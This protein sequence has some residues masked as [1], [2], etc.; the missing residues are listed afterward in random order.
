MIYEKILLVLLFTVL[1]PN[2]YAAIESSTEHG[3]LQIDSEVYEI[4]PD[5]PTILKISG[6]INDIKGDTRV[7]IVVA[8]PD[9]LTTGLHT[10]PTKDGYFETFWILDEQSQLGQYK[11]IASYASIPLGE[12]TFE[13]KEKEYSEE[14][15]LTAR[16]LLDQIQEEKEATPEE[17]IQTENESPEPT[18]IEKEEDNEPS[19]YE[20]GLEKLNERKY[21]D[22]L[23]LFNQALIDDP[24]STK[25]QNSIENAENKIELEK[26][27]SNRNYNSAEAFDL[28]SECCALEPSGK[29]YDCQLGLMYAKIRYLQETGQ[30][31]DPITKSIQEAN[32]QRKIERA[33]AAKRQQEENFQKFIE[34]APYLLVGVAVAVGIGITISLKKKSKG[35]SPIS[36]NTRFKPKKE[37]KDEMRWEGI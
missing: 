37:S 22:A 19:L 34:I 24:Q 13:V 36:S 12:V 11:L 17:S 15:L 32:E 6:T 14:E 26:K 18:Q 25:I 10:V 8:L 27:C 5:Q 2:V 28:Y 30:Y 16:Q 9:E 4:I 31:V 23:K 20:Q 7:T 29:A 21:V 1:I 3:S 35:D 33:E